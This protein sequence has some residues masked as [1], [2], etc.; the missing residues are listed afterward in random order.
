MDSQAAKAAGGGEAEGGRYEWL[1]WGQQHLRI[2]EG[3]TR[4]LSW[5]GGLGSWAAVG[6]SRKPVC[7]TTTTRNSSFS[8]SSMSLTICVCCFSAF[9]CP[10]SICVSCKSGSPAKLLP[11]SSC[12][13]LSMCFSCLFPP[14]L[15]ICVPV[16]YA[17]PFL[18]LWSNHFSRNL[19]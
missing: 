8:G 15:S 19:I 18:N 3:K 10:L 13:R 11:M 4:L 9:R 5:L 12:V 1:G 16:I 2:Y 7:T 17:S 6:C 14:L